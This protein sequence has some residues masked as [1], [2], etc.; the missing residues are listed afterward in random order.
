MNPYQNH[1]DSE[2]LAGLV[3]GE[4]NAFEIIYY[5]YVKVLTGYVQKRISNRE[6]CFEIVQD[7]FESLWRRR[8]ALEHITVLE[9]YLFR[10]VKYKIIRYFQHNQVVKKYEDHFRAFEMIAKEASEEGSEIE[11]LRAVIEESMHGL[12][13]RCQMVVRLRVEENLTNGDIAKRMH[14]NKA[15]VKRY[16]T[17]ALNYFRKIHPPLYKSR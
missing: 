15:T 12:P 13:E 16:M 1:T 3:K 10:M 11:S 9:A 5:R 2:L 8:A 6:D 7:V 14:I 17:S 4:H